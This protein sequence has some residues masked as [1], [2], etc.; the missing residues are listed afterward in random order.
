VSGFDGYKELC[1][2][3]CEECAIGRDAGLGAGQFCPW[4][5]RTYE[6]GD[7][8]CRAGEPSDYVWFV[9]DGVV[10]L[11]RV[12]A[13]RA[14]ALRLPG[15]FVGLESGFRRTTARVL[16]RSL[17]CGATRERFEAWRSR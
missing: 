17:L 13:G 10:A 8:L 1:A 11:T 2:V 7:V 6:A 12:G 16:V 9:K 14:E 3:R 5:T 15:S 4:I